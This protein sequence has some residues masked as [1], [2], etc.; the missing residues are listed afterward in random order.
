MS[1]LQTALAVIGGIVTL[2]IAGGGLWAI[3]IMSSKDAMAKRLASDNVYL[4][5]QLDFIEPRFRDAEAKNEL[6][7]KLHN[8]TAK[9]EEMSAER[10]ANHVETVRLL[11]EQHRTLEE[12]KKKVA[13]RGS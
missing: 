7:T 1:S 11:S 12:I 6:L 13:S 2:V 3:F 10:R 4:R 8:P 9:L 5:G